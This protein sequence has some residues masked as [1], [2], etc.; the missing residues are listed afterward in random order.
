MQDGAYSLGG[1]GI[2]TGC[3]SGVLI[4]GAHYALEGEPPRGN[5]SIHIGPPQR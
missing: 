5:G 2:D 3:L 1:Y 4:D